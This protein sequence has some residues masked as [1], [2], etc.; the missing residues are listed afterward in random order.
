[1]DRREF[2]MTAGVLAASAT[3]LGGSGAHPC[4]YVAGALCDLPMD[5]TPLPCDNCER[6]KQRIRERDDLPWMECVA[7]GCNSVFPCREC[8][9]NEWNE[10]LPAE[11]RARWHLACRPRK[12]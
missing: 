2:L 10:L 6:V 8:P 1:M 7:L 9:R 11:R 12:F 5:A 3:C 4:Y